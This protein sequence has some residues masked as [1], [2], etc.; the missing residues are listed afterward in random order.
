[1]L[2]MPMWPLGPRSN[3]T[4]AVRISRWAA[5]I[6]PC[7]PLAAMPNVSSMGRAAPA[8]NVLIGHRNMSLD[9][10][11]TPVTWPTAKCRW[12]VT[13]AVPA[14]SRQLV[15]ENKVQEKQPLTVGLPTT[16]GAALGLQRRRSGAA[17]RRRKAASLPI[18]HQ[19][20]MLV[21]ERFGRKSSSMAYGV[22]RRKWLEEPFQCRNHMPATQ[23]YPIGM[24]AGLEQRSH[25][26]ALMN[27]LAA[28]ATT[29]LV[30][31]PEQTHM[32]LSLITMS[33]AVPGAVAVPSLAAV[34]SLAAVPSRAVPAVVAAGRPRRPAVAALW[35]TTT[36]T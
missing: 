2:S 13:F 15:V 28:R 21:L 33:L 12:N 17:T 8:N 23:A 5:N 30:L 36:T 14:P 20:V 4:F 32:L 25:G 22:G 10:K 35:C 6:P 24:L 1:M 11:E 19:I 27:S 16:T 26:A 18:L 31:V 34:S 3:V 29:T 9:P 7:L